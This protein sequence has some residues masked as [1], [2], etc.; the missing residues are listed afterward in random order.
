MTDRNERNDRPTDRRPAEGV[1]IIGAEEAQKALDE[2]Q[3]AGRRA[4]YELKYGDVPPAPSGPRPA[5]R[6][7][8]PDSVDP[9]EA[10]PRPPVAPWRADVHPG[11]VTR[12]P[13]AGLRSDD[14][15]N[16]ASEPAGPD[17]GAARGDDEPGGEASDDGTGPIASAPPTTHS[18][19]PAEDLPPVLP[20]ADADP[21][22][23]VVAATGDVPPA[24]GGP[25][26]V[27]F[28]AE[29]ETMFPPPDVPPS[30]GAEPA[31]PASEVLSP[32]T[33][34]PEGEAQPVFRDWRAAL[35]GLAR[36][37]ATRRERSAAPAAE[38]PTVGAARWAPSSARPS[39]PVDEHEADTGVQPVLRSDP[40]AEAALPDLAP[41]EEGI[42]VSGSA[43]LPHWTEP[44][45]GLPPS[46]AD[47]AAGDDMDAWNALGSGGVR[48]RSE[49]DDWEDAD[50]DV[51]YLGGDDL[52]VG[53]LDQ[54]R[55]DESDLYSFDEAFERLEEERSGAHPAIS[56]DDE[57][58]E[59]IALAS[60]RV[61][62]R[63]R[64]AR[65]ASTSR[66]GRVRGPGA[67]RS[68]PAGGGRERAG[69]T[70]AGG[71]V[72]GRIAVGVGLAAL[73]V[74]AYVIGPVALLVLSL[75]A[76]VAA[77]A[78]SYRILQRLGGESRSEFGFRPATLLG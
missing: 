20:S 34:P 46:L 61:A 15:E 67:R 13:I 4:D 45:G 30:T 68:A 75:A 69:A 8:L 11:R 44:P 78:E 9:A 47:P 2:G 77:S 23:Q 64:R 31:A 18:S 12:S 51:G 37:D 50:D 17:E 52:R 73:L 56:L 55:S 6:F 41:P 24:P 76:V 32:S 62:T 28:A 57:D 53:A 5:H 10:V 3:A 36:P 16:R 29:D 66:T 33:E 43:E 35:A 27:D 40:G 54:D 49:R 38:D 59:A 7:P 58:D 22:G 72:G 19:P 63:T 1:R 70:A 26:A 39:P 74:V 21:T 65:T 71:D 25:A 60:G 42:T 14:A 48:W